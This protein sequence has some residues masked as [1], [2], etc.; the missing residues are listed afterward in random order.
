MSPRSSRFSFAFAL[1]TAC[2]SLHANVDHTFQL[3]TADWK[4]QPKNVHVAGDFNSW[5]T[6]A[7]AL[8]QGAKH[9]WSVKV[10]LEEG[11]HYYKFVIDAGTNDQRWINDPKA[12]KTLEVSDGNGGYNSGVVAGTDVSK[13]PPAK[14]NDINVQAL[15]FKPNDLEDVSFIDDDTVRVRVRTLAD[16]VEKVIP[17][18]NV[19]S[20][21]DTST[22]VITSL[23]K[24]SSGKGEDVW[25]GIVHFEHKGERS[26]SFKLYDGNVMV[27]LAPTVKTRDL[28][29]ARHQPA[30]GLPDPV[31]QK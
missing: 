5:S 26:I 22:Q 8:A 11:T 16:D 24:V 29:K 25:A 21:R 10:D 28:R 1:L 14:P 9:V 13:L 4:I 27:D 20:G 30:A 2:A 23:R 18:Q 12:D 17:V 19:M 7:S 6:D 15:R 31:A 3:D